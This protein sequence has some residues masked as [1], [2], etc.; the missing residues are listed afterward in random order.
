M[1]SVSRA[2]HFVVENYKKCTNSC[3]RDYAE[4]PVP[5]TTRPASSFPT[6]ATVRRPHSNTKFVRPAAQKPTRLAPIQ[7]DATKSYTVS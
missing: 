1:I 7:S 3:F 2:Y 6:S 5:G 4:T